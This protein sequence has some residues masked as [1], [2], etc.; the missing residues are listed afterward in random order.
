MYQTCAVDLNLFLVSYN[1][2]KEKLFY[3]GFEKTFNKNFKNFHNLKRFLVISL[4][5]K[6][7]LFKLN[8]LFEIKTE[9]VEKLKAFGLWQVAFRDP[10]KQCNI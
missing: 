5:L 6:K 3:T 8:R 9:A 10:R 1:A 7:K 4:T 2:S